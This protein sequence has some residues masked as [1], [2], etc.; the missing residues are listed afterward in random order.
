MYPEHLVAPMRADIV[1]GGFKELVF[2]INKNEPSEAFS[3]QF[4]EAASQFLGKVNEMRQ[5][6]LDEVEAPALSLVEF[7][8]DS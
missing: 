3:R 1:E 7:G 5:A 2:S 4:V 8:K 6:Q